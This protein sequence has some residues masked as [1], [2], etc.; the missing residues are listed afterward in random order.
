M[1]QA[2]APARRF[3]ECQVKHVSELLEKIP[4]AE[5]LASKEK[6][7]LDYGWDVGLS[8]LN[9]RM[10]DF[11]SAIAKW[12]LK[13]GRSAIFAG[14]GL[15]KTFMQMEWARAIVDKTFG[16]VLIL[17]PFA[18]ANQTVGEGDKFG[19]EIYRAMDQSE[20][21]N[22]GIYVTNYDRLDKFDTSK[23]AGVVLDESSILKSLN[24]ATKKELIER[25]SRTQYRLCCTATPAPNDHME[26]GN[27]AEFLGVMTAVEMLATWFVHDGGDTS[28]WRL[29]GH[30]TKDFWR[31]VSSWAVSIEKPSD[32]GFSDDGYD[33]PP[34]HII[35]HVVK[36]DQSIDTDGMLF[37]APDMSATGLHKEMRLTTAPRVE[38]LMELVDET[39]MGVIWCNTDYEADEINRQARLENFDLYEVRGSGMTSEQK[40][41]I[42]SRFSQ[43]DIDWILTKSRIAGFGMNW[44]H[45][46]WVAFVGLSYSYEQ[47]YQAIRRCWRFGQLRPVYV[48]II[49]AE[50]EGKVAESLKR[51]EQEDI[52]MRRS[53]VEAM[54]ETQLDGA[55]RTKVPYRTEWRTGDGWN[56]GLGDSVEV[57]QKVPDDSVDYIIYSPPFS[58]LYCY[59]NSDR[60]MG[61]SLTYRQFIDHYR[62]LAKELYR[63]LKPG[64]LLS[65]HCMN[66]PLSKERDGVIGQRDFRGAL[67]KAHERCVNC[68]N[69]RPEFGDDEPHACGN[70]QG[71][72]LHSETCIWKDPVTAMQRTKAI[73]LLYKQLRKDSALSRQGI[74]DYLIT[75]RKDGVNPDP[76]TKTHESFPV[77]EWQEYASPVWM[78]IDPSD[79]LQRESAREHKDERHIAPLQLQVISRAIRLWTNPGDLVLSPFAGIGSEG[80]VALGM[81]RR[82]LGV[83]LKES[84][85]GQAARNLDE[86]SNSIQGNLLEHLA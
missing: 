58:S 38:K 57:L 69:P 3:G 84:Y 33:L 43:G 78:D 70:Y 46:N 49:C 54:R 76:V 15:G 85:F 47:M 72:V 8:D 10:K 7:A 59:S 6:K 32:L 26:L 77:S 5:F 52:V 30:A 14:T 13:R 80:V 73:G 35:E 50:T 41:N 1:E 51:K 48:H 18:V 34:L 40:E 22:E 9:P 20:C 63:V 83:E 68:D 37:R 71:M 19:I 74:P 86:Q 16:A 31:W 23:F 64:R 42:L 67:I 36:V 12:A 81:G 66:L 21:G 27:H 79:T 39:S 61:N 56:L 44:Q 75:M 65:F 28:K 17:A 29:K 53:L 4:Y 24:G 55:M 62:F 2:H 82:F 45:C 25:F 11:Q 60:D